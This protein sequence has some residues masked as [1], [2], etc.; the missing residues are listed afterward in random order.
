MMNNS[1]ISGVTS[2]ASNGYPLL[3]SIH[4]FKTNIA[5][6]KEIEKVASLLSTDTR[7]IKWSIDVYDIDHVL[8]IESNELTSNEILE[9]VRRAGYECE[10]L[11]D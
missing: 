10:E 8:R 11:P 4:I 7:I 2:E 1:T 9:R 6:T 5:S 3:S